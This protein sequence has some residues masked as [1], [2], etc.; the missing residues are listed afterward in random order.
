MWN[1]W[2]EISNLIVISSLNAMAIVKFDMQLII[3]GYANKEKDCE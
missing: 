1:K 2:G 3:S